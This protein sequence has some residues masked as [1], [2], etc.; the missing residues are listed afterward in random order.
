M[1]TLST[2]A[3][4][5]ITPHARRIIPLGGV[6]QILIMLFY[7]WGNVSEQSMNIKTCLLNFIAKTNLNHN[8][9][10]QATKLGIPVITPHTQCERGKVIGVGVPIYINRFIFLFRT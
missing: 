8:I 6:P 7:Y 3:A 1:D 2:R 5:H 4:K 9:H 10:S